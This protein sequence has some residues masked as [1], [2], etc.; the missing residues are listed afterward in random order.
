MVPEVA[1]TNGSSDNF[2]GMGTELIVLTMH[3]LM[4]IVFI[5]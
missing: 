3:H 1:E 2:R 5:P 4:G